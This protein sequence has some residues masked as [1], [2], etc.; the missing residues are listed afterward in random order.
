MPQPMPGVDS[1]TDRRQD[2]HTRRDNREN[3]RQAKGRSLGGGCWC[4]HSLHGWL[5]RGIGARV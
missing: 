4:C 5:W 3:L 2:R 1:Q